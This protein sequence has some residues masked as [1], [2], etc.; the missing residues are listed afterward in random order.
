MLCSLGMTARIK[1]TLKHKLILALSF[2]WAVGGG[3]WQLSQAPKLTWL[4]LF[5]TVGKQR[6]PLFTFLIAVWIDHHGLNS[7]TPHD[8]SL[9]LSLLEVSHL[10]P[11]PPPMPS[12]FW[13]H[14]K[15]RI[16]CKVVFFVCLFLC[17]AGNWRINEGS[18]VR[19]LVT[20]SFYDSFLVIQSWFKPKQS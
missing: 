12:T 3:Q 7:L 8:V 13:L 15:E 11:R 6:G 18:E 1:I 5:M 16:C 4:L 19:D 2:H 17:T 14:E 9:R 20:F 10:L